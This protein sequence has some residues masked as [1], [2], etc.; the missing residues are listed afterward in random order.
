LPFGTGNPSFDL[1]TVSNVAPNFGINDDLAV[2]YGTPPTP[3]P[4]GS[5]GY[6]PSPTASPSATPTASPTANPTATPIPTATP[7]P[8]ATPSPSAT[9]APSPTPTATP[10]PACTK[11]Q[12]PGTPPTCSCNPPYFVQGSGRCK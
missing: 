2:W 5:P 11:N 8:T 1:P 4:I 3:T 12:K 9:P 6:S 7:A 10:L